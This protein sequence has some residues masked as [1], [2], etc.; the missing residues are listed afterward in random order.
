MSTTL[1]V[2]K[3]TILIVTIVLLFPNRSIPGLYI[4]LYPDGSYSSFDKELENESKYTISGYVKDKSN[5][6]Y[7][8][9]ANVFVKET[10]QGA[11]TNTYGFYSLTLQEGSY[12]IVAS[13]IGYKPVEKSIELNKN[14]RV[15]IELESISRDLDA[16]IVKAKR[17]NENITSTK[18]GNIKMSSKTI[19]K[20]PVLLG[21]TDPLKVLRLMPGVQ[22]AGEMSSSF[23]VRGGNKDQNLIQLDEATVYNAS[24]MM[25]L[26]SVFNNDAIKNI[27]FY[28]GNIPAR[29]G[30]RLSSVLDIKMNEGNM[31]KLSGNGGI[32]LISSRLSLGAPIVKDKCAFALS[33]RRTYA[34]LFTKFSKN[35]EDRNNKMH[36]YDL[37]AKVNTVINKNN[38]IFISAYNG[39]DMFG[40]KQQDD[41][42]EFSWGNMTNTLRW[43]HQYNQK[44]FSNLS[45]IYSTYDYKIMNDFTDEIKNKEGELEKTRTSVDWKADL[46]EYSTKADFGYY[47][48]PENTLRFGAISTYRIFD[49]GTVDLLFNSEK[50][51]FSIDNI[52]AIENAL[53]AENEQKLSALLTINYGLRHS[54]F[55]NLFRKPVYTYNDEYEVKDTLKYSKNEVFNSFHGLEPRL[56]I[57]YIL[58]EATSLKLAY[59]RNRQYIQQAAASSSGSPL[60]VWFPASKTVDPQIS[61]QVS[62][63]I[64]KNFNNNAIETSAEVYYKDM[65]NQID[66][67][68]H[69]LLLLNEN[70]EGQLRFGKARAFGLEVLV[71]KNVGEFSGWT[72]YTLSKSERKIKGVNNNEFYLSPYDRTHNFSLVLM[73]DISKRLS[74]STNW[75]YLTGQPFT[76]PAGIYEYDG[77]TVPLFTGRNKDRMPN[78][79]RLDLAITL[80]NKKIPWKIFHGSWN[81]SV[82]NVYMNDNPLFINFDY[83][84]EGNSSKAELYYLPIIP[85]I[86]YNFEF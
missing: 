42:F 3:I 77:E 64:F 15:D 86:S 37:N 46:T 29:F 7:L 11:V 45:L 63:G 9:G 67:K 84:D 68:D 59:S 30:G 50:Y 81:L 5:G 78:Y 71:R 10:F 57:T 19:E 8:I 1:K 53:Y 72:S 51:S 31:K 69:A 70:I 4:E 65:Q 62:L 74:I 43:N 32:G 55:G 48:N 39:R 13:Y 24:H 21:E 38:R 61:D 25:G 60:D 33:G 16:V 58:D 6:E 26:F 66:F 28:K 14:L 35:K 34:D 2:W 54:S 12:N 18:M 52:H 79:H 82:Y 80:K 75:V 41:E 22:P 85:A 44:L 23:S 56:G 73:Y 40:D 76:S 83:D 49:P 17:A 36:F 27:E 47:L 20:V